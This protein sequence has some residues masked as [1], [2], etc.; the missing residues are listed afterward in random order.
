MMM[1]ML[2]IRR[3]TK[4]LHNLMHACIATLSLSLSLSLSLHHEGDLEFLSCWVL[5]E[6]FLLVQ[7]DCAMMIHWKQHSCMED[8]EHG[9]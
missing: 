5:M 8:V 9:E 4:L 1:M 6:F 2:N 7:Q 3:N